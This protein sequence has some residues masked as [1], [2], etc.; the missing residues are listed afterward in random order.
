[1]TRSFPMLAL[2]GFALHL[3]L[4][5]WGQSSCSVDAL[6]TLP[7]VD[8]LAARPLS[9][10]VSH[11][12]VEGV[13]GGKIHFEL[14][15]PEDWNGKF[16]MGGG[17][18]FV[19]SVMNTSLS[20]GA[21]Q[22]GYASVG[23]DTGHQG[24]PLSAS[25]A[26]NDLE[27]LVNF[28]HLAVH[29][30]AVTAKALTNAYYRR[31][32][33]RS[34]FTGCSRGGGQAIMSALRYPED[35][36]AIV[37][38]AGAIDWTGIAVLA[39]QINRAMY[40]DPN[41]LSRAVVGP[42][43]QALLERSY[44]AACDGL[45]GLEDG[46]LN[47]P[48]QC[49]FDVASLQCEAGPSN[50]CLSTEEVAAIKAVYEAPKDSAG[51]QL[52]YGFSF[53][54]E[55]SPNGWSRWLTGGLD[56]FTE[57]FQEGVGSGGFEA[58]VSPSTMFSFGN[59][60]MRNFIYHDEDWSYLDFD[61]N[62]YAKDSS[63]AAA[64]LNAK[65]PDLS[66][67]RARGGKLLIYSGWSESAIPPLA[68]INH[69]E[70][71]VAHDPTAADDVRLFMMPGVEHCFGGPGPSY[72]NFLTEIDNWA[73]TGMAPDEITAYWLDE[74]AQP[75]GARPVCAY[76]RVAKYDGKGNPKD[77]SSFECSADY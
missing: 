66:A 41:N 3:P 48:R 67:F 17:G 9:E 61:P 13:I 8:Y 76:P 24:H 54:G 39:T 36:D 16:V 22:S 75:A 46:I 31:Q 21:L 23:T 55:T 19:G 5:A 69:Y 72:V 47:D 11:C 37:A 15:L 58:P 49:D 20:F 2:T 25:W 40:P 42:E 26:L 10:P 68:T 56:D 34:Y 35:F 50:A 62:A 73:E 77:P 51:N 64:T 71:V 63:A 44:M 60:I 59:G 7:D 6:L 30:T 43:A 14:L 1:M 52:S 38:G 53:G 33:S 45:D 29:R 4:T 74:N 65:D 57:E 28:G 27:A 12:S 32:I 18:G 70:S